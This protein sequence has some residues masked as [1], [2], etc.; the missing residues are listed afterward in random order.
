MKRKK[1]K[2]IE[3]SMNVNKKLSDERK[4]KWWNISLFIF[5]YIFHFLSLIIR[6]NVKFINLFFSLAIFHLFVPGAFA[7]HT[8]KRDND[9]N[10]CVCVCVRDPN[11]A[12]EWNENCVFE[13]IKILLCWQLNNV[14]SNKIEF[15][16]VVTNT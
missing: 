9:W 8:Q 14:Y 16:V 13:S 3:L 15:F 11:K 5:F 6:N 7:I 2:E 1:K 10:L 12:Y 4:N